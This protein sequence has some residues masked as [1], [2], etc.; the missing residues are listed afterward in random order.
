ME[1]DSQNDN[2]IDHINVNNNSLLGKIN[3]YNGIQIDGVHHPMTKAMT[4]L[5]NRIYNSET[6][7]SMEMVKTIEHETW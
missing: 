5:F 3:N 2:I 4:F 1:V 7:N 6:F